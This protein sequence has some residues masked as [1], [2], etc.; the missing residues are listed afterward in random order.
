MQILSVRR[1]QRNAGHHDAAIRARHKTDRPAS[2][3]VP[4]T[5]GLDQF[6]KRHVFLPQSDDKTGAAQLFPPGG[7]KF[8]RLSRRRVFLAMKA[9]AVSFGAD[10]SALRS[11]GDFLSKPRSFFRHGSSR[12]CQLYSFVLLILV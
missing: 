7:S 4:V 12:N 1:L 2:C 11:G 9:G 3:T 6:R 10:D 5:S 8:L